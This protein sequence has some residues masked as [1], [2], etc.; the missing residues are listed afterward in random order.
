[1]IYGCL[2]ATV[3]W[4]SFSFQHLNLKEEDSGA[5]VELKA[6]HLLVKMPR[7]IGAVHRCWGNELEPGPLGSELPFQANWFSV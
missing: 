4:D 7:E 3:D 5:G 1:M 6:C 2:M